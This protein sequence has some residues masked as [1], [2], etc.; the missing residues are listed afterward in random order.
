[1]VN[2]RGIEVMVGAFVTRAIHGSS[3]GDLISIAFFAVA[4]LILFLHRG[5]DKMITRRD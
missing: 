1:M 3:A 5:G 2:N 4:M